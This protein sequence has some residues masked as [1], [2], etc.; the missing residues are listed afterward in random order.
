MGNDAASSLSEASK[1]DGPKRI[2]FCGGK[3]VPES[4]AAIGILD[5]GLLYGDGVFDTLVAWKGNLFRFDEHAARLYRSMRAIALEPHFTRDDLLSR[6]RETVRGNELETAYIKWIVTRG[7]NDTPLMDPNG[8]VPHLIILIRP[9]IERFGGRTENGISLK[10]VAIRR[11]PNQCLD[12]RIKSLNYLNLILAK[13]EAKAAAADEALMLDISGNV[14]E[15]AGYN[16]FL[17]SGQKLFTPKTDILEGITRDSVFRIAEREGLS[18]EACDLSLYDAYTADE[19]F[20]TS[21]AGGLIPVTR[22]DGREIGSARPG[23]VFA[24]FSDGYAGMLGS[25][26]WGLPLD[27]Q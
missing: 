18:A 7:S 14:C 22:I 25:A 27:Q 10:T 21:T 15:A 8:C 6:T 2:C 13:M 11:T 17:V 9:Y 23:P 26:E 1:S 4:E 24:K 3:L 20:L 16:I 5:H 19:V 12:A